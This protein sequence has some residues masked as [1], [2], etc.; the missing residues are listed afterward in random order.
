[1]IR[2]TPLPTH[3]HIAQADAVKRMWTPAELQAHA[4]VI[5]AI[6]K[7]MGENK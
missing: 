3:P 6:L 4:I 5:N 2:V 7:R 1:M